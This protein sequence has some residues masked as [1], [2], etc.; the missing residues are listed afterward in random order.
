MTTFDILPKFTL[1]FWKRG[2]NGGQNRAHLPINHGINIIFGANVTYEGV[3]CT[4][5]KFR[6]K[7]TLFWG[8]KGAIRGSELVKRV[9]LHISHGINVIFG[10]NV[11]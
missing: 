1:F 3:R 2:Q 11:I 6:F 9:H 4:D 10:A 8:Y 5:D 7:F